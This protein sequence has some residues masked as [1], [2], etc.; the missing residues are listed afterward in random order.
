MNNLLFNASVS[1]IDL[2]QNKKIIASD[3]LEELEEKNNDKLIDNFLYYFLKK[4]ERIL[5][6]EYSNV[7][8]KDDSVDLILKIEWSEYSLDADGIMTNE[9]YYLPDEIE[10]IYNPLLGLQKKGTNK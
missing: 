10:F 3:Y 6:R 1:F 4:V 2:C 8:L 5:D 9:Y 7:D